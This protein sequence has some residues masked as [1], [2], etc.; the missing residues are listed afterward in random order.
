MKF[1]PV[2]IVDGARSPFLKSRNV[3]GPFSAS[4]L[5]TISAATPMPGAQ[6]RHG[7]ALSQPPPQDNAS[8]GQKKCHADQQ[9]LRP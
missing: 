3:P 4:D 7:R 1:E 9:Q 6:C 2:Y 5:A 8:D